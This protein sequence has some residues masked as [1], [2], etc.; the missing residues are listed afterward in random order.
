MTLASEENHEPELIMLSSLLEQN[1]NL[2]NQKKG[3]YHNKN[4]FP[5]ILMCL[6]GFIQ[7]TTVNIC[8]VWEKGPSL[9]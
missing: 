5:I 1:L 3:A 8:Q 4:Y 2:C 6:S 7:V 9:T